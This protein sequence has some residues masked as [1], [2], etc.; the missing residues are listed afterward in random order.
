MMPVLRFSEDRQGGIVWNHKSGAQQT[1]FVNR[2]SFGEPAPIVDRE[3]IKRE[4]QR[5]LLEQQAK[6]NKA[7]GKARAI[8]QDAKPAPADH[9]YLIRKQ[10]KPHGARVGTWARSIQDDSGKFRKIVIENCLILPMYNEASELRS[11]AG[12]I[13]IT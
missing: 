10:I 13:S 11:F 2:K 5:R 9:P 8:W 3:H 12:Y 4:Q 1:F 7:A 6:Q